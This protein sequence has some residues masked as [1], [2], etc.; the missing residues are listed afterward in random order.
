MLHFFLAG[1][2]AAFGGIIRGELGRFNSKEP[3]FPIGTF[4]ANIIGSLLIGLF[5]AMYLDNKIN[6]MAHLFL[7]TGFCGGLTTFSTFSF[8]V[9]ELVLRKEKQVA[10]SYWLVSLVVSLSCVALTFGIVTTFF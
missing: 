9:V 1:L 7:V 8:E 3:K 2:G 10:L 5:A 6:S 4:S